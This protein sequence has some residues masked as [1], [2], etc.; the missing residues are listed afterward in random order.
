MSLH[1]PKILVIMGSVR[2]GRRC[3]QIADLVMSAAEAAGRLTPELI[4]LKE[5][6]LPADDEPEIPAKGDY[7]REHTRAW[8]AKVAEAEGFVL[9]SPQYNWGYPAPLKN[10][11]DHLSKE[12]RGKPVAIV[13]YGGHGG[14]KCASQL[15][16]LA[17]AF[18]MRPTVTA[19]AISVPRESIESGAPMA[20]D[21]LEAYRPAVAQALGELADLIAAA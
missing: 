14:G 1:Q 7:K 12:W 5:W 17:D 3:P 21:A 16:Q 4:D 18:K 15:L 10:A 20:P 11:L 6:P 9:V 2:S 13:T 19:P 8:S